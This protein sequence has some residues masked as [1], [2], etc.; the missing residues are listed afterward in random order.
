[1]TLMCPITASPGNIIIK[2]VSKKPT[3]RKV[4]TFVER[5]H[6]QQ[7]DVFDISL[8]PCEGGFYLEYES[9]ERDD[10]SEY[11]LRRYNRKTPDGI[12]SHCFEMRNGEHVPSY[13]AFH[14]CEWN[15]IGMFNSLWSYNNDDQGVQ[16][17]RGEIGERFSVFGTT[18][19]MHRLNDAGT[20]TETIFYHDGIAK[21]IKEVVNMR[22][23]A[24]STGNDTK[25]ETRRSVE[26]DNVRYFEYKSIHSSA[27]AVYITVSRGRGGL[28]TTSAWKERLGSTVQMLM[29]AVSKN[30]EPILLK[31]YINDVDLTQTLS[32]YFADVK[33]PADY[34]IELMG[35]RLGV[36]VILLPMPEEYYNTV[37][38][39]PEP[40]GLIMDELTL[41]NTMAK[42]QQLST[43]SVIQ[44]Y[45]SKARSAS[46]GVTALQVPGTLIKE[47]PL[48]EMFEKMRNTIK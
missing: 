3:N 22:V 34:E 30:A 14:T 43:A 29:A 28:I 45:V 40:L 15:Q 27:K 6:P 26:L 8:E 17:T 31:E 24:D 33:R 5:E 37:D 41:S 48:R 13:S 10:D 46:A 16:V 32:D 38:E 7:G 19:S 4:V 47:D 35:L 23:L 9:V 11:F 44:T 2:S 1:M 21:Y 39:V 18:E 12:L 36:P 42:W 25:V 20:G